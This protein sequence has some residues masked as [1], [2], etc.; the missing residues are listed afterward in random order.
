MQ[1]LNKKHTATVTA[2]KL[3]AKKYAFNENIRE[4]LFSRNTEIIG[5]SAFYDCRNLKEVTLPDS[6]KIIEEDAFSFSNNSASLHFAG[7]SEFL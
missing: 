3:R 5:E 6:L 1:I 7:C 4:V 2:K